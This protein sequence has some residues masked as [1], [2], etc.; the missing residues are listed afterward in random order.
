MTK[1]Q[2]VL[3]VLQ[4]F[5]NRKAVNCVQLAGELGVHPRTVYRYLRDLRDAGYK[6][7]SKGGQQGYV[8]LVDD[9]ELVDV[10]N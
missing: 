1:T 8:E 5:Q 4:Q 6:F 2:N 3:T 9:A 10:D 7:K